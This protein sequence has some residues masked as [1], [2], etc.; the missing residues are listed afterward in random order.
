[1]IAFLGHINSYTVHFRRKLNV[2]SHFKTCIIEVVKRF[3][4]EASEED[5]I[6]FFVFFKERN[7]F[8]K[9]R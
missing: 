7:P 5:C 2:W 3:K 6:W 8:W 1:M 9:Y 4:F